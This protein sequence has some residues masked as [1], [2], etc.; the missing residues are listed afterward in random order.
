MTDYNKLD[1]LK[2]LA[3]T[4]LT[5]INEWTESFMYTILSKVILEDDSKTY[6]KEELDRFIKTASNA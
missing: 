4:K 2:Y 3:N 1:A 5:N 6:T